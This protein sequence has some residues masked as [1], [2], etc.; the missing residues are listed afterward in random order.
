[1]KQKPYRN[2]INS[3]AYMGVVY[4]VKEWSSQKLRVVD[5]VVQAISAIY[6]YE[7]MKSS[8]NE[9]IDAEEMES[10]CIR[11]PIEWQRTP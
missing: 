9:K 6:W 1:M 7:T 11:C 5:P 3:N 2:A 4:G 10:I 8:D